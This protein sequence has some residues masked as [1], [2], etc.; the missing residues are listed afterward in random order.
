MTVGA[1]S[2]FA[3]A[4]SCANPSELTLHGQIK[5]K[6]CDIPA[7]QGVLIGSENGESDEKPVK[8]KNFKK[9]QMTQ[10]E[11]TQLQLRL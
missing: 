6:F 9:F 10:V 2:A 11:V 7:A 1:S 5:M 3:E 4:S 8:A